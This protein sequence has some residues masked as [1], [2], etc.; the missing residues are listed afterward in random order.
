MDELMLYAC[1]CYCEGNG[2]TKS[3]AFVTLRKS[4]DEAR[5]AAVA[6]IRK[7]FPESAGWHSHSASVIAIPKQTVLELALKYAES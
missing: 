2:L 3:Y 5:Q 7:E 1:S 6:N 4:D